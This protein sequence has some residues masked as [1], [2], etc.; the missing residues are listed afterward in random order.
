MNQYVRKD[1]NP[2]GLRLSEPGGPSCM[3]CLCASAGMADTH[4][5][6]M[7][8]RAGLQDVPVRQDFLCDLY[9]SADDREDHA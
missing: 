4:S 9:V 7:M 2:P 3:K 6:A 5:G 1:L 8:C